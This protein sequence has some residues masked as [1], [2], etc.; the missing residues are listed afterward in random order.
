M[1]PRLER[2]GAGERT[3]NREVIEKRVE[4]KEPGE[5]FLEKKD[6]RPEHV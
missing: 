6:L 4:E 2:I 5:D 3:A 1:K